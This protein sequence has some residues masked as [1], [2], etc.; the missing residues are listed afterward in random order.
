MLEF[1]QGTELLKER[2]ARERGIT[3]ERLSQMVAQ[4]KE[5][6]AGLLNEQAAIYA[7][8]K[9]HGITA[10]A[11]Q[12]AVPTAK[13]A[14][15]SEKSKGVSLLCTVKRIQA[16]KTFERNGKKG[17]LVSMQ[18]EDDSGMMRMVL[19]NRDAERAE[20]GEIEKGD[21]VEIRG[22]YVKPSI[23][24]GIELHLGLSGTIRRA[25]KQTS[26]RKL[27]KLG[28]LA[29]G[30]GEVDTIARII[31]I[32]ART[33]FERNGKKGSVLPCVIGDETGTI[34]LALWDASPDLAARLKA[35][36]VIKVENGQ[37]RAGQS[38][39][40]ELHVNW[41][42]RLIT[43]PRGAEVAA[44]EEILKVPTVEIANLKQG[45]LSEI[46][47]KL[48]GFECGSGSITCRLDD[49]SG[50]ITAELSGKPALKFLGIRRLSEDILLETAASLKRDSLLGKE[51][52]LLGK[53]KGER[54]EVESPAA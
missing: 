46:K 1:L 50:E 14:H 52:F 12:Q 23:G 38:G 5:E 27:L 30:M 9:E 44:R 4:K 31:E 16:L 51:F 54:F 37:V 35:N 10:D 26:A 40:P 21:Q 49:G 2:L 34:R 39:I 25:E 20:S 11:A 36:D 3:S 8:A 6:F 24:G 29:D 32:G 22:A 19:W 48:I 33:D 28:A 41:A 15:L 18:V 53:K 7:V 43:R 42:G 17:S 13:I 47:A 45:E